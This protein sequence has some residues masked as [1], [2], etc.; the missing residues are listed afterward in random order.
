MN[1]RFAKPQTTAPAERKPAKRF[2]PAPARPLGPTWSP[3]LTGQEQQELEQYIKE[4][5]LP[6]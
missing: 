3:R 5:N 2:P 1:Q 4:N 6:F